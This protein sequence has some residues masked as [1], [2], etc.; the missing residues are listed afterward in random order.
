[1]KKVLNI[2]IKLGLIIEI[3]EKKEIKYEFI[4]EELQHYIA[5]L[6]NLSQYKWS[7]I[8]YPQIEYFRKPKINEKK[9][10]KGIY[11]DKLDNQ[12]KKEVEKKNVQDEEYKIYKKRQKKW[13]EFKENNNLNVKTFKKNSLNYKRISHTWKSGL[14]K[15]IKDNWSNEY[16]AEGH[17]D[18]RSKDSDQIMERV[19]LLDY[20]HELNTNFKSWKHQFKGKKFYEIKKLA[21]KVFHTR[22]KHWLDLQK[23]WLKKSKKEYIN[24]LNNEKNKFSK[25]KRKYNY[26][27]HALK[28]INSDFYK[29]IPD[30]E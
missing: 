22:R 24:M 10:L 27:N 13:D 21:E 5:S 11:K 9:Y 30:L 16:S 20:L 18:I 26:L 14:Y 23:K 19:L 3:K 15:E 25:V 12:L 17:F 8:Q 2:F 29:I 4:D 28:L 7:F 1:A 6:I